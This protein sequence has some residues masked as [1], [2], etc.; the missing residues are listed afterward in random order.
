MNL[1]GAPH[2]ADEFKASR[3]RESGEGELGG[4]RVDGIDH[5]VNM[6]ICLCKAD[7]VEVFEVLRKDES[8]MGKDA[9]GR[10]DI[11]DH[12]GHDV[13]LALTNRT[14]EGNGLT[15]DV[16]GRDHILVDDEEVPTPPRA[17]ASTQL[18]PT[19]PQPNTRTQAPSR[20]A[21]RSSPSMIRRRSFMVSIGAPWEIAGMRGD[22]IL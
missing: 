12:G 14:L 5:V 17:S 13:D 21:R 22:L 10:A 9:A 20:R 2:G 11:C 18:D 8:V 15:V 19:P 3:L 4:H 16:G 6:P 7:V 1:L